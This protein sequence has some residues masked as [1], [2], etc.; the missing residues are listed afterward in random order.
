MCGK[1]GESFSLTL[2]VAFTNI[3]VHFFLPLNPFTASVPDN[4]PL[5]KQDVILEHTSRV[6]QTNLAFLY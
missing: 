6:R 1:E 3:T 5:G 2:F 4:F